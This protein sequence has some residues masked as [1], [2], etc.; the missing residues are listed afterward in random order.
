V[1]DIKTLRS[2][3]AESVK[4]VRDI[5]SKAR[6]ENRAVTEDETKSIE[7]HL[8]KAEGLKTALDGLQRD[9]AITATIEDLLEGGRPA[10]ERQEV[11]KSLGDLFL[12]APEFKSFMATFG[13]RIPESAKGIQ[14]PPVGIESKFLN[15]AGV[16]GLKP[17]D[18]RGVISPFRFLGGL[19]LLNYVTQGTT[20]TDAVHYVEETWTNNAAI[21]PEA[22]SADPTDETG[23]KPMS[24]V[25]YT[26]KVANV[27]TIAHWVPVTK[28][29]LSDAGQLRTLINAGLTKGLLDK[30][31]AT[32]YG[33]A[34]DAATA[35]T[36]AGATENL[37]VLRHAITEVQEAGY[38]PNAIA[39]RPSTWEVYESELPTHQRAD[40]QAGAPA[41]LYGLPVVVTRHAGTGEAVVGDFTQEFIWD[42]EQTTISVSDSHENFF[43]KNLVAILAELRM[44]E[45]IAAPAAFRKTALI[46]GP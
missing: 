10:S 11:A 40:I 38:D 21:V 29:A 23:L 12:G 30:V 4:A 6:D 1:E 22:D 13:G 39:M 18:Q 42:R 28:N 9:E 5:Q 8:A 36:V 32:A 34:K 3:I 41:M 20:N 2:G 7:E 25:V 43:V 17:Y 24:E 45:A 35:T 27:L 31:A 14:S 26:P 46:T 37:P 44:A 19:A 16:E 33:A 15:L